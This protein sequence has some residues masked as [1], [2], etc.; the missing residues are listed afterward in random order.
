MMAASTPE[1]PR[2]WELTHRALLLLIFALLVLFIEQ[3]LEAWW[4][5]GLSIDVAL[6]QMEASNQ[7]ARDLRLYDVAHSWLSAGSAAAISIMAIVLFAP[8]LAR[9]VSHSLSSLL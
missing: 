1:K 9:Q 2:N 5:P 8:K 7:V 4:F 3:L 6:G